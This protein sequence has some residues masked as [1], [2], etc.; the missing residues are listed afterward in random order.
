MTELKQTTIEWFRL[1]D[2]PQLFD[3]SYSQ[4]AKLVKQADDDFKAKYIKK[5]KTIGKRQTHISKAGMLVLANMKD[6]SR[7]NQYKVAPNATLRESKK[8]I[9][10]RA[11]ESSEMSTDPMLQQLQIMAN[12]RKQQLK[13]QEVIERLQQDNEEMKVRMALVEGDT[14]HMPLTTGQRQR[15]NERVR[16]FASKTGIPHGTVWGGL[17]LK[18]GRK[19]IDDYRFDDYSAA[20]A[21]LKTAFNKHNIEW[22]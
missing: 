3:I 21:L 9:A 6:S 14:Q 20:I 11:I 5:M 7:G 15:I 17:H 16:L 22:K 8:M 10:E 19:K 1:Q 2:A 13:Q 12:I 18:V 4:L